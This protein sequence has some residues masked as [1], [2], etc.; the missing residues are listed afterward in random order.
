MIPSLQNLALEALQAALLTQGAW[1]LGLFAFFLLVALDQ[2]EDR[3]FARVA[4]SLLSLPALLPTAAALAIPP[5]AD[6]ARA[7][8][9]VPRWG[10]VQVSWVAALAGLAASWWWLRKGVAALD[11]LEKKITRR[12]RLERDRRTDVREIHRM[13]PAEIGGF[14]PLKFIRPKRGLFIGLDENKGPVYIPEDVWKVSHVLLS[15]RTRS[16]KGVAAQILLTQAIQ[17]GEFVVVLDPKSDAWM[18]YI[19]AQAAERAGQPYRFLDLRPEAPPQVNLFEGCDR[20][21][22][23]TMLIAAFGL[24]EKGDA[25]D[26]YRLG[27]RRAARET[28]AFIAGS[29]GATPADVLAALGEGW[30]G[31]ADGFAAALSEMA[32]LPSVNAPSGAGIEINRLAETGGCL[33]VVGDMMNT[34]VIRM[35]RMLL[36]RLMMYAKK[37]DYISAEPR[38]ITVFADEFKV[39]ISK[40]FMTSLGASAGWGLHTIL[41]FQSL[42]DLADVPADLDKD[43]VR[44]AV[45]ENCAIQLSY[46]IKD[47]DTADWL[48]RSTGTILVDD[49]TRSV[50]K[51]LALTEIVKGERS[52]RQAERPFIDTN[53]F[54]NMPKGCGVLVGATSLP[55]FCYTSPVSV[56]RDKSAVTPTPA[57][58]STSTI[59]ITGEC[60]DAPVPA[61]GVSPPTERG[62]GASRPSV[63]LQEEDFL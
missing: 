12:T 7:G 5:L 47:P 51:N 8:E 26:F 24:S 14:D 21:T 44:G 2:D 41:A 16:G 18:P 48:S 59:K 63:E 49:E 37:R 34:R 27:D 53:M 33:Y 43:A 54:M 6:L 52:I 11:A 38:T 20:E 42:Q 19:F 28:A 32:Q 10:L 23:E 58:A 55:A 17:R 40:P 60:G 4:L 45:M 31:Q 15:G 9:I 39:H 25:A 13:L 57:V 61:R 29:P 46:R 50:A 36:V 22:I 62:E 1:W 35:Q 3:E 30:Q 56:Q